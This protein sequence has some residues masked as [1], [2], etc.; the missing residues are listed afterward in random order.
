MSGPLVVARYRDGRLIKGTSVDVAA[1]KPTCY[2]QTPDGARHLV[3]LSDL[4][5]LFFVK[6]LEGNSAHSE[7]MEAELGD[8]RSMGAAI[9]LVAFEDGEHLVGFTNRFPPRGTYFFVTP[10]DPKS[11]NLRALVN[12]A[13]V[14]SVKSLLAE[15]G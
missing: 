11:N 12:Q 14:K 2:V 7:A 5:A 15:L 4:K 3:A 1:D 6:T 13:A 10:V 8:R 9:V